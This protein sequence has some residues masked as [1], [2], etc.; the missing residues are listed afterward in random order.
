MHIFPITE[1]TR[2]NS[3]H[4]YVQ[5]YSKNVLNYSASL[6]PPVLVPY[7]YVT[8]YCLRPIQSLTCRDQHHSHEESHLIWLQTQGAQLLTEL[9]HGVQQ[10]T[11]AQRPQGRQ[12]VCLAVQERDCTLLSIEQGTES[13]HQNLKQTEKQKEKNI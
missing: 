13:H 9:K 12:G 8:L 6:I 3:F 10:G 2:F 5:I 7:E 1:L 4:Y 11:H